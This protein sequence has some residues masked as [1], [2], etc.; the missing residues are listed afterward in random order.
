MDL[1]K[2][3][4][5]LNHE[6]FMKITLSCSFTLVSFISNRKQ[7]VELNSISS[8][9]PTLNT[10]VPQGWSILG[11]VWFLIYIFNMPND[12]HAFKFILYTDDSMLLSAI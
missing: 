12:S 10:G 7:Y 8:T 2:A 5:M 4:N 9:T 3:F 11:P 6:I 1:S